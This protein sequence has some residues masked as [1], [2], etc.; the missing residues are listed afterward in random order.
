MSGASLY[1]ALIHY[2]VMNKRGERIASAV[3]NLDLHDIARAARTYGV[4][5]YYVVTPLSDQ[6]SLVRQLL[7]HWDQGAGA[8]YNPARHRALAV[9]RL[10]SSLAEAS[11]EIQ[12]EAGQAPLWIATCARAARATVGYGQLREQLQTGDRPLLICLGTAW[13][14]CPDFIKGA[15]ALL[16]PIQGASEYNH[17]SVRSA[18]AIILDRLMGERYSHNI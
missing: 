16:S 14:L 18:A 2:P 15:D 13:G 10:K 12:K 9:V 6:Q 8:A 5:G 1:L 3:T 7:H 4:R 17:L 11:T